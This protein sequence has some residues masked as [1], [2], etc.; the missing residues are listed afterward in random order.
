LRAA[1]V[2]GYTISPEVLG[3]PIKVNKDTIEGKP[4]LVILFQNLTAALDASGRV[5]SRPSASVPTSWPRC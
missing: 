3:T 1:H 4:E 5:F 2:R